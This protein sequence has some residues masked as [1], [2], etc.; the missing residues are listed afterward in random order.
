MSQKSKASALANA[1]KRLHA[2]QATAKYK[3]DQEEL[4]L[5]LR[6][7]YGIKDIPR[8]VIQKISKVNAGEYETLDAAINSNTLLDM[9]T[10]YEAELE[11]LY[12]YNLSKGREFNQAGRLS[13]ELSYILNRYNEYINDIKQ[14]EMMEYNATVAQ[15]ALVDEAV[16][17]A[18]QQVEI[19][20]KVDE[21]DMSYFIDD[22]DED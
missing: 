2:N 19:V 7:H 17:K 12:E 3:D 18:L 9:F 6:R 13:Y 16:L 5:Y 14:K 8:N 22:D 21:L 4:M 10:Y 20:K 11:N 15:T 1:T